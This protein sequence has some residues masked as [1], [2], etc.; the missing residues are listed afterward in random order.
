MQK[1]SVAQHKHRFVVNY[2][3]YK[4]WPDLLEMSGKA[5]GQ[6]VGG[7]GSF[8]RKVKRVVDEPGGKLWTACS[9]ARCRSCG[10]IDKC[11]F[12]C[13]AD[14]GYSFSKPEMLVNVDANTYVIRGTPEK[15]QLPELLNDFLPR[16]MRRPPKEEAKT[17]D[18][19]NVDNVNFAEEKND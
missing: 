9:S 8:R 17:D 7:K 10:F 5:V 11:L 1:K 18:L 6:K 12:M 3:I 13:S 16:D 19:G 4:L 15:K 2:R 14:F